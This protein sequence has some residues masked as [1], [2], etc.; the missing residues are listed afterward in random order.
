VADR[1][2]VETELANSA[3][4]QRAA[5][6]QLEAAAERLAQMEE[7][8]TEL[9]GQSA[10][11][12]QALADFETRQRELEAQLVAIEAD[13]ARIGL[14]EAIAQRDRLV[15]R[16]ADAVQGLVAALADVEEAR[17]KVAEAF[18][19]ARALD[20][21]T[22][23][24]LP[25]EPAIFRE[26]WR[27]LAPVVEAELGRRLEVELV[28][29]AV[30]SPNMLVIEDLPEHLRELARQRKREQISSGARGDPQS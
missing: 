9:L 22:A 30:R 7:E 16:A 15:E 26:G 20:P 18:S 17:G 27:A 8:R 4:R 28:E 21:S 2:H 25:P 11:A 19:R 5:Q 29:A 13:E 10:I 12:K 6:Q 14:V 24:A 1:K 3:A 23:T